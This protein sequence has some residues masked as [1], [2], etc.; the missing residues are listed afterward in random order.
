[1]TERTIEIK[2]GDKNVRVGCK[3]FLIRYLAE[4]ELRS[5]RAK[6]FSEAIKTVST[7]DKSIGESLALAAYR[8]YANTCIL[9]QDEVDAWLSSP[10]GL[11]WQ[12]A[13]AVKVANLSLSD[14]EIDELYSLIDQPEWSKIDEFQAE[15]LNP[16]WRVRQEQRQANEAAYRAEAIIEQAV[17]EGLVVRTKSE[18]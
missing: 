5:A 4:Q 12:F 2:I 11:R 17:Q 9:L 10:T 3:G 15:L 16:G 7:V 18:G 6:I 8:E 14:V 13:Q 1:V